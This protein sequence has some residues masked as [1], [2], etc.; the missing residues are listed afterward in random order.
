MTLITLKQWE[1]ITGRVK[2][3]LQG[4]VTIRQ[5]TEVALHGVQMRS[6]VFIGILN[7]HDILANQPAWLL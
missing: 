7:L 4:A 3:N 1:V 6:E 5:S 2:V